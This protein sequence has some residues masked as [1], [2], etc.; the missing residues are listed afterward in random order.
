[1]FGREKLSW[2]RMRSGGL[3]GLQNR[4]FVA[5]QWEG[6]TPSR[7]RHSLFYGLTVLKHWSSLPSKFAL[8]DRY[9]MDSRK[10]VAFGVAQV[11]GWLS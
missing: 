10:G 8:P 5:R 4:C 7:S 6:S 11:F 1:M 2:E 9:N 3:R